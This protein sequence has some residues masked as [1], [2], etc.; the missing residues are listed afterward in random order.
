MKAMVVAAGVVALA[1]CANAQNIRPVLQA[2]AQGDSVQKA[3]AFTWPAQD[4]RSKLAALVPEAKARGVS[5]STLADCGNY[6]LLLSVRASSG[7]A[8]EHAHWD[9]VMMVERGHATLITGGTIV[10]GSTGADGETHGAKIENGHSQQIGPGD[11]VTVHAGTPHQLILPE[12][13]VYGALVVKV[14][15]LA[16][17][18]ET[19]T[20][21]SPAGT[22]G[23]CP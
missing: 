20:G 3:R 6:K 18:S 1:V 14:Q 19:Q 9:D 12:G 2:A 21:R 22:Q 16:A 11:V 8:E 10:D 13:M 23:V 5:G 7:G 15:P 17:P 4:L